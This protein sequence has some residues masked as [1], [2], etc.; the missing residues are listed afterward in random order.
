MPGATT[1]Q[2]GLAFP[3]R[4]GGLGHLERAS[5][6]DKMKDMLSA[7]ILTSVE[8]RAM[9]PEYG[10]LGLSALFRNLDSTTVTLV[11]NLVTEA[12][13]RY[14]PRVMVNGVNATA[15]TVNGTLKIEVSYAI[16]SSG[17]FDDLIVLLEEEST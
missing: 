9:N 13:Y 14:E 10:T 7:L 4:F 6:K 15:D 11:K 5:G 8:D 3:L 16:K 12:I 17:E 2:K 1:V